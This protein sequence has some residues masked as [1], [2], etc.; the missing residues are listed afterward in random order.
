[1][2]WPMNKGV[3]YEQRGGLWTMG[4]AM[5]NGVAYEQWGGL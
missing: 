5:D 3:A 1:M 2:G 4:W